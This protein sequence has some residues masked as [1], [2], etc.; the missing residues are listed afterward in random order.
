MVVYTS[1]TI[2]G[3]P[4]TA[5]AGTY[6]YCFLVVEPDEF[7]KLLDGKEKTMILVRR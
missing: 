1:S 2:T 7:L 5:R 6:A 4:V 3:A